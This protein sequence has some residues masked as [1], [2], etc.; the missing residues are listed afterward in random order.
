ML[1]SFEYLLFIFFISS[2]FGWILEIIYRSLT[3][4]KFIN[5]GFL[6]GPYVPIYGAGTIILITIYSITAEYPVMIRA[7]AYFAATTILEYVTGEIL[8]LVFHRRYWDYSD[9]ALNIRGHICPSFSIF[10][11]ILALIFEKTFYPLFMMYVPEL[12]LLRIN[13]FNIFMMS[14]MGLDIILKTDLPAFFIRTVK[15]SSVSN[16]NFNRPIHIPVLISNFSQVN[17]RKFMQLINEKQRY[18]EEIQKNLKNKGK[19]RIFMINYMDTPLFSHDRF[20]MNILN[21]EKIKN[22]LK[23]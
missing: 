11:I 18:F 21:K 2:F 3:Q 23:R 15:N 19:F 17:F 9:E 4:K 13:R 8:V 22:L 10:W 16:I 5:P 14:I 12:E 7:T 1:L 6:F 20:P